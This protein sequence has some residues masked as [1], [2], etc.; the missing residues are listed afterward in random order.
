MK[1]MGTSKLNSFWF[2]RMTYRTIYCCNWFHSF[3]LFWCC[4]SKAL[5]LFMNNTRY[6]SP[7]ILLRIWNSFNIWRI[8]KDYWKLLV[9]IKVKKVASLLKTRNSVWKLL[10]ELSTTRN[11]VLS[12]INKIRLNQGFRKG[13]RVAWECSLPF[14]SLSNVLKG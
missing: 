2:F 11:L 6:R 7:S 12:R 3:S 14:S 13:T 9:G 4:G 5:C 8:H 10:F 1:W